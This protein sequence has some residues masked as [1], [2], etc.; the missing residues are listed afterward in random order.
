V[1]SLLDGADSL[2]ILALILLAGV[3]AGAIF[4]RLKM[5]A[6][7]GQILAGIVIGPPLAKTLGWR[8]FFD[9]NSVHALEPLTHF[10]LGLVAVTVGFISA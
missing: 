9:S 4:K 7:T 8:P 10:A 5:P 2:L 3:L 1:D 6:V